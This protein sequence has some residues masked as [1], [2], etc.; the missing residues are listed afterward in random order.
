MSIYL[1]CIVL[2]STPYL[3]DERLTSNDKSSHSYSLGKKKL[4]KQIINCT[5][6]PLTTPTYIMYTKCNKNTL[7]IYNTGNIINV[8]RTP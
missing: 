1:A 8:L 6:I 7:S 4:P 2:K 5:S 3:E